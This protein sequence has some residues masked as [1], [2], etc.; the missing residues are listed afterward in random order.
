MLTVWTNRSDLITSSVWMTPNSSC[1]VFAERDRVFCNDCESRSES[2]AE[3]P[4]WLQDGKPYKCDRCQAMFCYNGNLASH[5]SVHT[6]T[7]AMLWNWCSLRPV[8]CSFTFLYW[9][10]IA[11]E[12]PYRCSVCGAQFN[13]PANLKTHSRIHSGEKPYKC[14]TCGSC[15]VQVQSAPQNVFLYDAKQMHFIFYFR[16]FRWLTWGLT[17]WSTP[18]RN[19][20]H[21]TSAARASATFRRWRV[22]YEYTRERNLIM[23]ASPAYLWPWSTKALISSTAIFV[24]IAN[25]TLHGSK[26]SNFLLCQK[27]LGY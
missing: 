2:D 27:S 13:R 5:K 15:F 26:W 12:K 18:E 19:R 20:T 22:T 11:G 17:Y 6:G 23:W 10:I 25:N 14:E 16:G 3:K 1:V 4:R 8:C 7:F 24:A 9:C 21:V